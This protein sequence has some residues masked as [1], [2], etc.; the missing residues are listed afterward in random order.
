MALQEKTL[1]PQQKMLMG[2]Y[3]AAKPLQN[4]AFYNL[5]NQSAPLMSK[6]QTLI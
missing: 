6:T 3:Y 4:T 5:F 1:S 2:A